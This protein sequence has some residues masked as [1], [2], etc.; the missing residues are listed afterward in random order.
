M[1]IKLQNDQTFND[2]VVNITGRATPGILPNSEVREPGRRR[3][4]TAGYKLRILKEVDLCRGDSGAI[5]TLLRK[6]GLYSSYLTIWR[7][8]RESGALS[9]LS[10]KRGRKPRSNPLVERLQEL[11][12][13]H[14]ALEAKY[15]Q[16]L[17]IIDVQKKVSQILGVTLA[18]TSTLESDS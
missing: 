3:R 10:T 15:K 9:A 8:Q 14:A 4:M 7:K 12:R 1:S 16:S 2:P 13:K 18:D 5:A 17:L 11:E 6:E